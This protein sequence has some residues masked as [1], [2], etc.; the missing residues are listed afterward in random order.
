MPSIP[1]VLIDPLLD[2]ALA[3]GQTRQGSKAG[4]VGLDPREPG[5]F[6]PTVDLPAGAYEIEDVDLGSDLLNV[7]PRDALRAI[8]AAGRSPLTLVE[9]VCVLLAHPGILREAN[10]F[11]MLSS[12]AGDKR[13]ASLWVTQQ[14]RPRLGWCWEGAPHAWMGAASCARR[15]PS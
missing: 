5:D 1:S 15:T 8:L 9:G 6:T 13:I 10:A 12:R 4:Y 2:A 14:G 3:M 7:A 11:Q